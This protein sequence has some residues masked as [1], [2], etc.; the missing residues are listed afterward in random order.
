MRCRLIGASGAMKL[1]ARG[2]M[3]FQIARCRKAA[4]R[5]QRQWVD[6]GALDPSSSRRP[7]PLAV[8]TIAY[9]EVVGRLSTWALQLGAVCMN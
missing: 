4:G 8:L 7:D 2:P 3:G 1:C 9:P 5:H 6:S